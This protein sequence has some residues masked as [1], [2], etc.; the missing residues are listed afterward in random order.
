MKMSWEE[1]GEFLSRYV[2]LTALR[3]D[4]SDPNSLN[5]KIYDTNHNSKNNIT[6]S[7]TPRIMGKQKGGYSYS[8]NW[9]GKQVSVTFY[10]TE[11]K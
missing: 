2:L 5:G 6:F 8:A 7:R 11:A 10:T 1:N 4:V 9:D 3:R